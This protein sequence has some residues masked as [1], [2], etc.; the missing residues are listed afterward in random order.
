MFPSIFGITRDQKPD[1]KMG[2]IYTWS[3]IGYLFEKKAVDYDLHTDNDSLTLAKSIAYIK[4][5]KPTLLMIHFD[6][7]DGVGHSIGHRTPAYYDMVHTI[8]QWAGKIQKAVRDAGIEENTLII[9]T[10]DHGG[11]GKGHGGKSTDEVNIPWIAVGPGIKKNHE[12]KDVII[13]FDTAATIAYALGLKAPQ[14]WRG[15]PVMDA[16]IKK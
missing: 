15:Q 13:T 16:F 14:A 1:A 6:Q 4:D 7:P 2:V 5:E 11:K 3:G 8:D 12:I 9:L 10:A